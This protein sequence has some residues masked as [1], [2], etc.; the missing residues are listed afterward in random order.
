MLITFVIWSNFSD[1]ETNKYQISNKNYR[2][3]EK[4][5]GGIGTEIFE[6]G[7]I[8]RLL[9]PRRKFHNTDEELMLGDGTRTIILGLCMF[10]TFCS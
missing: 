4:K 7:N 5:G 10:A 1:T 2:V 8:M 9:L 3:I 6:L